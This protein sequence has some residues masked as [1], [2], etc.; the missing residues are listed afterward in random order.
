MFQEAIISDVDSALANLVWKHLEKESAIEN[1]ISSQE[2]ISFSSPKPAGTRE[3]K[4]LSIFL[5]NITTQPAFAL[6]YLVTPL[7]GKDKDD[8]L[9]LE[10]IIHV[11]STPQAIANSGFTVKIDSLSLDELSKLWVA[12]GSPLRP[13]VNLTCCFNQPQHDSQAPAT[14]AIAAPQPKALDTKYDTQ[15]YQA[16]LETFTKQSSGWKNRNIVSKQWMLQEF[17]KNTEMTVE[18]MLAAL[19]S[20]GDKLE[21][22][23]PTDQFIKPLNSLALFYKHQL[24]ELEGMHKVTHKQKENLEMISKWIKDV[25]NLMKVLGS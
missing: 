3:T 7:T 22:H 15:I 25:E 9:L 6:H 12:L 24:D 20:L 10:T 1:I 4:K 2:Q 13:S 5:Y 8:H 23:E 17:K 14:G 18:E 11:F 21:R 16:V 19:N